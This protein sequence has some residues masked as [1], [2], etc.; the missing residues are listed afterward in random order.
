MTKNKPKLPF[1]TLVS[2]RFAL[3]Q[4]TYLHIGVSE[5]RTGKERASFSEGL[6]ST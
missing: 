5:L 3:V 2:T 4:L 1:K 6:C